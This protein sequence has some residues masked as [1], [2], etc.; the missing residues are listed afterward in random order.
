M[1][2][3]LLG[4]KVTEAEVFAVP[5]VTFTATYRPFHHRDIISVIKQGIQGVG[6]DIVASDYVL[7]NEGK[8]M[9]G[10]FDLSAGDS[11]MCYSVGFRN[12]LDKSM[13]IGLAAGSRVFVCSNLCFEG[14][15]VTL[16]RRHT[17]GL[18]LD[19]LEF[20]AWKAMKKM[21]PLLQIFCRYHHSLKEYSLSD[22]EAKLLLMEILAQR[23]LPASKLHAFT[24]LYNAEYD[25][26]LYGVHGTVTSLLKESNLMTVPA[27]SKI[28]NQLMNNYIYSL[29]SANDRPSSI[30]DFY[31]QRNLINI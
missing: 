2:S 7:A 14:S 29:D 21:I 5:D 27:K 22:T 18:T 3:T 19:E 20:L 16:K 11:E 1:S 26:T 9:F 15:Y 25:S 30:G 23:I 8:K 12:S 10:T 24:D 28:L 17:G 13:S 6:M 4:N 31:Q